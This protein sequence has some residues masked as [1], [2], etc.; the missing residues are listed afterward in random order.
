VSGAERAHKRAGAG[1]RIFGLE[2]EYLISFVPARR[3]PPHWLVLYAV[4][5]GILQAGPVCEA[6][7]GGYFLRNGGA[8][9]FESRLE[10]R[11]NPVLELATPECSD[12]WEVVRYLRAQEVF[13]RNIALAAERILR[14]HGYPGRIFFCRA[15]RDW[16]GRALG[17]HENYWVRWR[18]PAPWALLSFVVLAISACLLGT[19]R[20][21][22]LAGTHTV[23]CAV[24][25]LRRRLRAIRI[26]KRLISAAQRGSLL[27]RA[28]GIP[29][30]GD[31]WQR[32]CSSAFRGLVRMLEVPVDWTVY[33]R[34][35]AEL[36]PFLV[37]RQLFAGSGELV[38][39]GAPPALRLS[40]RAGLLGRIC[41]L[42]FGQSKK[43]VF[44]AKPF[45]NDPSAVLR[46]A[47]RLCISGGDSLMAE[48]SLL[49]A[50][51]TTDLVL[52]MLE[53]GERFDKVHLADPLGAWREVARNA[54]G[55]R[56]RLASGSTV[57]ALDI[58]RYFLLRAKRFFGEACGDGH[59]KQILELW[60]S[61]LLSLAENP[62]SLWGQVDWV[63]KKILL[64]KL[65][66]P[67]TGWSRVQAWGRLFSELQRLLP[68]E[69]WLSS[70][71]AGEARSFLGPLGR[72]LHGELLQRKE[73]FPKQRGLY[74]SLQKLIFRYQEVSR[75]GGY[76][77]L[78]RRAGEV[79]ALVDDEEA[80]V[81]QRV[82]PARTRAAIRGKAIALAKDPRDIE[83]SWDTIRI[84]SLKLHLT[85]RDPS[86]HPAG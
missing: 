62:A 57:R 85:I 46:R 84:N 21:L 67:D 8:V 72:K 23:L 38:F 41:G 74:L 59:V 35:R 54:A 80:A 81:A 75:R 63:T 22:L 24:A 2:T 29:A 5:E 3:D 48:P 10:R 39:D 86:V 26:G 53:G 28:F 33:R 77:Q 30:A 52:R 43:A 47:H 1:R 17:T 14:R 12:P 6:Q 36:L 73:E 82:P 16:R 11:D 19:F 15:N 20:Y 83:A 45:L 58:Q 50:V 64:D 61:T 71:S 44:D 60:E 7:G 70:L 18:E 27:M 56:L 69:V 51:G 40:A 34:L 42:S 66:L 4:E 76:F 79:P 13:L 78:L 37:T 55:A 65:V 32:I 25:A 9:S 31:L 68:S 49:L